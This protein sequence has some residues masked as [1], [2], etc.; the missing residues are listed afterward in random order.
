MKK[1]HSA[2]LICALALTMTTSMMLAGEAEYE[3]DV[4]D[5]LYSILTEA[6]MGALD[7]GTTAYIALGDDDEEGVVAV[8]VLID[9]TDGWSGNYIGPF[10]EYERA[11]YAFEY[12]SNNRE[13][14]IYITALLL[15]GFFFEICCVGIDVINPVGVS[16]VIEAF[17]IVEEESENMTF[18]R[19]VSLSD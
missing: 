12:N 14:T 11:V 5:W 3:F 18:A 6:Y 9:P 13:I 8:L 7:D 15:D 10:T 2:I 19:F 17:L 1:F 4:V 16:E